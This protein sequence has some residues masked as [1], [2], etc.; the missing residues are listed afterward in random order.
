M[1][2]TAKNKVSFASR[3]LELLAGMHG[4]ELTWQLAAHDERARTPTLPPATVIRST[5][6]GVAVVLLFVGCGKQSDGEPVTAVPANA[7]PVRVDGS[8]TVYLVSKAVAEETG[9]TGL[10][11]VVN[12]SGTT[13]GFKKFCHGDIDVSGASRPIEQSEIDACK[14]AGIDF[15]ELPIGYDGLAVVV[16]KSNTWVDHLTVDE[17]KRMWSP[18]ATGTITSWKQ[19]RDG[20]PD[21]PLH[22]FGPGGDSGTFDYFTQAIVGKQRASRT[23]Y[24]GSEDDTVLVRGVIA[25]DNALGYFGYAYVKNQDKLR[26]VPIDDGN[27]SNGDGPI[28][29]SPATVANGTYQPLSR[30]IFIYA[31]TTSLK[32]PEVDKFVAFYLKVAH[33]L[34]AEVGYVSLPKRVSELAQD[35]FEARKTGSMFSGGV[36]TVGVTIEKLLET[37]TR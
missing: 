2:D 36:P 10:R 12:E 23:D 22:L 9:K 28:A 29:P 37:Q 30:P 4:P 11:A 34:S 6:V 7:E 14:Q 8:S 3:L 15:V 27:A 21:K 33:E 18:E 20:F 26:A 24:T 1:Q 16:N 32:R 19:I 31:S 35:R 5:I 13:G 25:D 17:L